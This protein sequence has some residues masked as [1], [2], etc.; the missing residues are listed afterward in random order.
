MRV[1]ICW[2]RIVSSP[3]F[4]VPFDQTLKPKYRIRP[5]WTKKT[6]WVEGMVACNH[7]KTQ[8]VGEDCCCCTCTQPVYTRYTS[9]MQPAHAYIHAYIHTNTCNRI[10]ACIRLDELNITHSVSLLYTSLCMYRTMFWPSWW[11]RTCAWER[12]VVCCCWTR[13]LHRQLQ[14]ASSLTNGQCIYCLAHTNWSKHGQ[15][16]KCWKLSVTS[17]V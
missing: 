7:S 14:R 6:R 5:N 2:T 13:A 12:A 4:R 11:G 15:T 10:L 8:N 3:T 16:T 17:L 9:I 1:F